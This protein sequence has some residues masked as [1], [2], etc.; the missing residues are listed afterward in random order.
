MLGQA[1]G[2]EE[3]EGE[4]VL[5]LGDLFDVVRRRAWVIALMALVLAALAVGYSL[6]VQTPRYEATTKM[7]IRQDEGAAQSGLGSDVQG[8]QDV[9][10]SMVEGVESPSVADGVIQRLDLS[11]TTANFLSNLEAEA[12]PSTWYIVI[13]YSD[14]DPQQAQRIANATSEEFSGRIAQLSETSST[15]LSATVWDEA[16][17]PK[18]PASPEPLRNGALALT[19]GVILGVGMAFLLER[20][21]DS[22][23]SPEEVEQVSG[24]PTF[25]VVPEFRLLKVKDTVSKASE[26]ARG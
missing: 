3:V 9:A 16:L 14:P 11:L 8:L 23:R 7:V 2:R 22:W 26:K 20:L 24:V 5:S 10:A 1:P 4:Y 19:L 18:E 25:G 15:S 17:L 21:D 13:S 12:V 6:F